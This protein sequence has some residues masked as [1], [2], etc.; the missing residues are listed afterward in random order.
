MWDFPSMRAELTAAGFTRI[1]EARLGDSEEP[2]FAAVEEPA[3][4]IDA[5]AIQCYA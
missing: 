2:G 3:R 4:W 1:R 5:V